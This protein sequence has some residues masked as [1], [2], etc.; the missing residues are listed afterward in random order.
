MG[1]DIPKELIEDHVQVI[2]DEAFRIVAAEL[3]LEKDEVLEEVI[4]FL[5]GREMGEIESS[6]KHAKVV[7]ELL[8]KHK[9]SQYIYDGS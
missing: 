8:R 1:I 2:E 4:D 7:H 9:F 6:K 5:A 3:G